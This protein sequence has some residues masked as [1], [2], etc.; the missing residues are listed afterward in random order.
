MGLTRDGREKPGRQ[1]DQ[2]SAID[3][4]PMRERIIDALIAGESSDSIAKWC[5]PALHPSTIWRYKRRH[6]A[7][8]LAKLPHA[9]KLLSVQQLQTVAPDLAAEV[10][11]VKDAAGAVLKAAPLVTRVEKL[12]K[13]LED[14]T[15]DALADRERDLKGIAAVS[16]A[17]NK[18][19]E[20]LGRLQ[21][22]P[23]YV[24]GLPMGSGI[25]VHLHV[26]A[27]A[28]RSESPAESPS[29][30][31]ITVEALEVDLTASRKLT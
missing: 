4:H 26:G 27:A 15:F 24:P 10:K 11:Q 2:V 20:T 30:E 5:K 14:A 25:H 12:V 8:L 28:Q 31:V 29:G 16:G 23:G 6:I 13:G 9:S 1:G 22:H 3:K 17:F 21:L 18:T 19:V 7:D